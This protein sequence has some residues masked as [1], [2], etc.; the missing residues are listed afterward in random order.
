MISLVL[1]VFLCISVSAIAEEKDLLGQ[2]RDT[3]VSVVPTDWSVFTLDELKMMQTAISEE[4]SHRILQEYM[5]TQAP[6]SEPAEENKNQSLGRIIDLFP[7]ES[8]A[9]IIRDNCG[10]LT[11]QSEL[12]QEELDRIT[13][14][15]IDG[16]SG[17]KTKIHDLTGIGYLHNLKVL[18]MIASYTNTYL[19]DEIYTLCKLEYLGIRR[20][21]LT[22]ISPMIGG[23]TALKTLYLS[24]N[25]ISTLPETIENLTYLQR[26]ALEDNCFSDF[27]EE[28]GTLVY[29]EELDI[30]KNNIVSLPDCIGNLKSLKKLWI[31]SNSLISLPDTIGDLIN[32]NSFD[33]H[34]NNLISLPNS[35]IYLQKLEYL[36]IS[37]TK[38]SSLPD[39]IG[40]MISLK[41]LNI[42]NTRITSLPS[43]LGDLQLEEINM[44]GLSIE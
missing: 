32:L 14:L 41:K 11:I 9:K 40:N 24:H 2:T 33:V 4:I 31:Y 37:N 26:L 16:L 19:P 34:E 15:T 12:T 13:S 30:S 17:E 38:I 28:I 21:E 5:S 3:T 42:S 20:T 36:S 7:D 29:L 23:L 25:K 43:S 10:K 6:S 18:N 44:S 35:I 8:L 27:P 22:E 39:A 1:S